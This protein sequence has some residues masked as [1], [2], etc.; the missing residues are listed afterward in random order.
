MPD[1]VSCPEACYDS[2]HFEE[3]VRWLVDHEIVWVAV[4]FCVL[5]AILWI[6]RRALLRKLKEYK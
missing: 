4:L 3:V 2:I 6:V 5:S 1:Q